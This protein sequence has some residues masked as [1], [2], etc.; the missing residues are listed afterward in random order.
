M[1]LPD[2]HNTPPSYSSTSH[3]YLNDCNWQAVSSGAYSLSALLV[4]GAINPA[5]AVGE[6]NPGSGASVTASQPPSIPD[7]P[8]PASG[9]TP[10]E[11]LLVFA[12]V[13]LY[14]LFTVYR[15]K[16]NERA[17]VTFTT[18][19]SML[20]RMPLCY[21]ACLDLTMHDD[22]LIRSYFLLPAAERLPVHSSSRSGRCKPSVH[23]LL[24]EKIVLSALTIHILQ[25]ACCMQVNFDTQSLQRYT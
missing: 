2:L 9:I 15:S 22:S 6:F 21:L 4:A 10:F 18:C 23:H 20:Y 8:N 13:L 19:Q 11:G 5:V 24:Q 12:P 7:I 3:L 1:Y 17:K 25:T 14:G 16:V